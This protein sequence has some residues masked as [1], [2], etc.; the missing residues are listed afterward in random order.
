M[1]GGLAEEGDGDTNL[2]SG[3]VVH[4]SSKCVVLEDLRCLFKLLMLHCYST[5]P[6]CINSTD[7]G[8]GGVTVVPLNRA[9]TTV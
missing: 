9:D 2:L 1:G 8:T 5:W 6:V 4:K 3:C 7:K